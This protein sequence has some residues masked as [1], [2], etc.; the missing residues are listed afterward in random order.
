MIFLSSYSYPVAP[1]PSRFFSP[2]RGNRTWSGH[3][4]PFLAASRRARS[5]GTIFFTAR[6]GQKIWPLQTMLARSNG[7]LPPPVELRTGLQDLNSPRDVS[8]KLFAAAK[9]VCPRS[10]VRWNWTSVSKQASVDQIWSHLELLL[11]IP[12]ALSRSYAR[13]LFLPTIVPETAWNL[14]THHDCA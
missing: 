11:Q 4:E 13:S 12:L 9:C 14:E 10:S 6:P 1:A 5:T 3:H 7:K 8:F 2:T